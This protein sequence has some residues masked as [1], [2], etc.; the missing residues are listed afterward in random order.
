[1]SSRHLVCASRVAQMS[2][3]LEGVEV[4]L[5]P[6]LGAHAKRSRGRSHAQGSRPASARTH[7]TDLAA[8]Q[9]GEQGHPGS[10]AR[11][12]ARRSPGCPV[13]TAG[14]PVWTFSW[15]LACSS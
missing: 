10:S 14:V 6:C 1:M 12:A 7:R 5:S 15:A 4:E 8:Q 2:P 13:R 11:R 3:P 9:Y